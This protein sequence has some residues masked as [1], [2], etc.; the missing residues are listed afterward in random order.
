[1]IQFNGDLMQSIKW[2][3]QKAPGLLSIVTQKSNWYTQ[4]HYNFWRDWEKTVFDIRTASNFG[5]MVWCIILGV[6]ASYLGL[7]PNTRAWAFGKDRENFIGTT[8]G[9]PNPSEGGNFYGGGNTT[10]GSIEEIRKLLQLRYVALISRGNVAFI[11]YMLRFIF[12]DNQPWDIAAGRYFYVADCHSDVRP[13]AK[14]IMEYRI[15]HGMNMSP[16]LV[17][18]L[19]IES[20]ELLPRMTG[21]K[22]TAIQE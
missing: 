12:N 17:A 8:P 9:V 14:F 19:N 7:Y 20:L 21:V 18:L 16:Q 11:N 15:G 6:P 22:A 10:V 1:M 3:Q 13:T 5:L 2:L 4:Y